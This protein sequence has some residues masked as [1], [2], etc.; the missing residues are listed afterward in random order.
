MAVDT[1]DIYPHSINIQPVTFTGFDSAET[2]LLH[3]FMKHFTPSARQDETGSI[4]IRGLGSPEIGRVGMQADNCIIASCTYGRSG[5][6]YFLP[7]AIGDH[8]LYPGTFQCLVQITSG[9]K[10]AVSL[11]INGYP[12]DILCGLGHD[13]NRTVQTT[14]IPVVGTTFR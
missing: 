10:T 6:C 9:C 13:E 12:T 3:L 8:R 1:T 14:E 11:C 4:Q 7:M 5:F 2:K